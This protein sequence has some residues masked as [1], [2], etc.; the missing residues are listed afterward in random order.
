MTS[1]VCPGKSATLV[2]AGAAVCREPQLAS[3]AAEQAPPALVFISS[4]GDTSLGANTFG[5]SATRFFGAALFLRHSTQIHPCRGR[6]HNVVHI[7]ALLGQIAEHASF[8]GEAI[9]LR[10]RSGLGLADPFRD[11]GVARPLGFVG[12]ALAFR[13]GELEGGL[14]LSGAHRS[15]FRGGDLF[16]LD[17]LRTFYRSAACLLTESLFG[18]DPLSD[19]I[20]VLSLNLFEGRLV[21]FWLREEQ[22]TLGLLLGA[23]A[24]TLGLLLAFD[25]PGLFGLLASLFRL[26]QRELLGA[27]LS[28][29][30]RLGRGVLLSL[31]GSSLSG[32]GFLLSLSC[33]LL[34]RVLGLR[35]LIA[36]AR[37]C[38][39]ALFRHQT[40]LF[41]GRLLGPH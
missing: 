34:A 37:L 15:T 19:Q 8:T 25:Q 38:L 35:C 22:R 6:G 13:G 36:L 20:L 16:T 40:G 1:L 31:G 28:F 3:A 26:L 21:I 24:D 30:L 33:R 18:F 7:C 27:S 10:L 9:D 41:G 23:A 29:L 39:R 11:S 14:A 5:D 4:G 17:E 12:F 2:R 32:G